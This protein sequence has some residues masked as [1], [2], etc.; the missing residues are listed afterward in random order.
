M[1]NSNCAN[2]SRKDINRETPNNLYQNT[3][4]HYDEFKTKGTIIADHDIH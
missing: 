1:H 2:K 4:G 3:L